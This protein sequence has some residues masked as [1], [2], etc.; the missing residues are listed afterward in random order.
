MSP[1]PG[2][3][4]GPA[5]LWP[6]VRGIL[7]VGLSYAPP[8]NPLDGLAERDRGLVAAY[9]A[10]R[11]Y[12]D[13]IK[14]RLKELAGLL[15]A[16]SG[17]EA[18]VFVDTAPIMEKPLAA[19]SG[20]GWIG[21]HTVVVSR[22]HGSWLLLGAIF[23]SAELP[24]DAPETDHCGT[25]RRC[26]DICPTDAFVAPYRLDAR[27]CIAY[28][29]IEHRGHIPEEFRA[30]I[31]NRVFGCDDCLAVC[32]WNK[33]AE[34]ARDA[35]MAIRD[36]LTAPRLRDL[37]GLDDD[38]F[39]SMFA[40]TPVKRTG[41]DRVVRNVLIAIGN[42]GDEG[43]VPDAIARLDDASPLVR[44]MAVW[45]LARL[46]GRDAVRAL[47]ASRIGRERDQA[48]LDEWQA[49]TAPAEPASAD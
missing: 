30:P 37:A 49:A 40:G 45:A 16:R 17:A 11:D 25:C 34:T 8:S 31:G 23:T 36:D 12:H 28:L 10:R 21:K 20:L 14:G 22:E 41:R 7:M 19:A 18:K 26:L 13:V 43:L 32:P 33:F 3:R 15:V 4:A 29:T 9:A 2:R 5:L 44:A 38:G 47:S 24:A 1:E 48:V 39:R 27:R 42:S 35:R 6:E 46:S